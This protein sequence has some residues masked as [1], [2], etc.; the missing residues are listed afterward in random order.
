MIAAA[1]LPLTVSASPTPSPRL[2]TLLSPPPSGFAEVSTAKLHGRFDAN[3]YASGYQSKAADA[4]D[5]MRRNGFVDGYAMTWM[6]QS[7]GHVLIEFVIAFSG[8]HGAKNWLAYEEAS[9]K[10]HAEYQ[11]SNSVAGIGQYYG[12]HLVDSAARFVV[13]GFSFVKGNDM[14]GVGFVSPKDDVLSLATAQVRRQYDSAPNETSPHAQW[15]E[16][17]SQGD[18]VDVARILGIVLILVFVVLVVGIGGLVVGRMLQSRRPRMSPDGNQWWDG[19]RWIES[20]YIPPPFAART[21]DGAYW[22][23]G[24]FWRPVPAAQAPTSSG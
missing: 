8:G 24:Q 5:T 11:H 13:D 21:S 16:A 18:T 7:T 23:D 9:D 6:Q 2:D 12:A 14:F 19:K 3:E 15:P 1:L 10:S 20:S 22:W 4:E 17:V